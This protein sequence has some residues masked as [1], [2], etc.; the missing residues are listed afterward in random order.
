MV[1]AV[2]RQNDTVPRL[3]SGCVG[4][5]FAGGR[6]QAG[7]NFQLPLMACWQIEMWSPTNRQLH[8][9]SLI[10][11]YA[12]AVFQPAGGLLAALGEA[13]KFAVMRGEAADVEELAPRAGRVMATG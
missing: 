8:L 3:P 12:S 4:D 2:L 5:G 13:E 6:P 7:L 11:R 1:P 9:P 10:K